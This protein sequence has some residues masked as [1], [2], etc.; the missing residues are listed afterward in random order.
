MKRTISVTLLFFLVLFMTACSSDENSNDWIAED[1]AGIEN[2]GFTIDSKIENQD[3]I[4]FT[5]KDVDVDL[6]DQFISELQFNPDFNVNVNYNY[7]SYSYTF[8]AFNAEGESVH[9][10]YN[11]ESQSGTFIYGKSGSSVF[12]PG[13]RDMGFSV[14]VSYDYK[15]NLDYTEYIASL[16]YGISLNVLFSD[17]YEYVVSFELT[18]FEITT[19]ST[20]GTLYFVDSL[21]SEAT[22]EY[23]K[24]GTSIYEMSFYVVQDA[25]GQYDVE[26]PYGE[27]SDFFDVMGLN[28]SELDFT[29]TFT[30]LVTTNVG[31]Y[32]YDYEMSLM[33]GNHDVTEMDRTL[34]IDNYIE[35]FDKGNPYTLID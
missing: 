20:Y 35:S 5:L 10:T 26:T 14:N 13:L 1:V 12:T 32:T 6:I 8:A 34:Y 15:S 24:S 19:A 25:I 23:S 29:L 16:F 17:Y 22:E 11:V 28:Q 7:D 33:P 18:D 4:T 21:Y 31:S 3:G 2:P 27:T 9:L 30:A